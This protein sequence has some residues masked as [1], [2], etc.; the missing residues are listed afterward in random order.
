MPDTP[1]KTQIIEAQVKYAQKFVEL[2]KPFNNTYKAASTRKPEPEKAVDTAREKG[3]SA[4][5]DNRRNQY[6]NYF[7]SD[8]RVPAHVGLEKL[9][10]TA[11]M[12]EIQTVLDYRDLNSTF[13][14]M[15]FH[16]LYMQVEAR[17]HAPEK[18]WGW[19]SPQ[20]AYKTELVTGMFSIN[21]SAERYRW[22]W[23]TWFYEPDLLSQV[24]RNEFV[25]GPDPHIFDIVIWCLYKRRCA[26]VHGDNNPH[27]EATNSIYKT[28]YEALEPYVKQLGM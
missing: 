10:G 5:Y 20:Q 8:P 18:V 11:A 22:L 7:F 28:A 4:I 19:D 2:W 15:T 26:E 6:V 17:I 16:E 21:G 24:V 9:C 13:A 3:W 14:C 12:S 27:D 23:G 25:A 1:I